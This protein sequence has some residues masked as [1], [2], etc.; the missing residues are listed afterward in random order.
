MGPT[1]TAQIAMEFDKTRHLIGK[2]GMRWTQ[3]WCYEKANHLDAYW[4]WSEGEK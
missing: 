1:V 4:D 2:K 3:E